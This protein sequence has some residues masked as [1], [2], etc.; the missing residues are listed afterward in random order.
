MLPSD[1][2]TLSLLWKNG[3]ILNIVL[4]FLVYSNISALKHLVCYLILDSIIIGIQ[5]GILSSKSKIFRTMHRS[6]AVLA[7]FLD[8][9]LSWLDGL[10][11][12]L[13][14]F[15]LF[16]WWL[17]FTLPNPSILALDILYLFLSH[18]ILFLISFTLDLETNFVFLVLDSLIGLFSKM[19]QIYFWACSCIEYHLS[20]RRSG[21]LAIWTT[22]YCLGNFWP[23]FI[24]FHFGERELLVFIKWGLVL[25][26]W[27]WNVLFLCH[28]KSLV[29]KLL[30]IV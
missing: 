1:L 13:F 4:W 9:L 23:P 29:S 6:W 26:D 17:L 21:S 10:H 11:I 20:Q 19:T 18:V 25:I 30:S 15:N 24:S 8:I 7:V 5:L 16:L 14:R 2:K 12:G 27:G 3:M 28:A 22:F